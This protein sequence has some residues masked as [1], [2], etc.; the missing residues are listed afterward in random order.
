MPLLTFVIDASVTLGWAFADEASP[1]A[2]DVSG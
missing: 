2:D 1:Y